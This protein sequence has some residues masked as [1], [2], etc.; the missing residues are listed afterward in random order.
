MEVNKEKLYELYMMWVRGVLDACDW[1]TSFSP[2]E[3]VYAIGK[4][5]EENPDLIKIE[6]IK[7]TKTKK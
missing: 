5:I 7:K 2:Q 1:K 4:I 6:K 3:I